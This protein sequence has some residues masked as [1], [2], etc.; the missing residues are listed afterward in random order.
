MSTKIPFILKTDANG[1]PASLTVYLDGKPRVMNSSAPLFDAAFKAVKTGDIAALRRSLEVK[2]SLIEAANGKFKLFEDSLYYNGLEIKNK[3]QE[4]ILA[5]YRLGFDLSSIVKFLDNLFQNPSPAA[6][7]E[8]YLF[9][10]HNNLPITDD[11]HFLAYKYIT[12]DYKDCYSRTFDYSIGATVRMPRDKVDPN[13]HNTCST[14]LHFCSREYIGEW[15]N[16]ARRL[17]AVKVNPRDVVS[18]PSDYN[19]SKG[20]CC[21]Y[22]IFEEI[23]WKGNIKDN[24]RPLSTPVVS[25]SE[26]E[27]ETEVEETETVTTGTLS[28]DDVRNIRKALDN[29]NLSLTEIGKMFGVHRT[30]IQRIRDGISHTNIR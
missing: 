25:E 13:R 28:A 8:L 1:N 2:K 17:V 16:D 23:G 30:T 14:G 6:Q 26:K 10:E 4:R 20:R 18:I 3:M 9:L 5:V 7:E 15:S 27:D 21:E 24:Y 12:N 11:G 19:N 29:G 22:L